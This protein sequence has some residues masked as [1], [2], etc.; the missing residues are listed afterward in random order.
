MTTY[1]D[2]IRLISVEVQVIEWITKGKIPKM[3][4][5]E[6]SQLIKDIEEINEAR[7]ATS[8]CTIDMS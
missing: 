5:K 7:E 4:F 1:I 6:R 3:S 2:G 8:Q